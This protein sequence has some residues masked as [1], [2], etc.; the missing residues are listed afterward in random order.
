MVSTSTKET[1][2]YSALSLL[3]LGCRCCGGNLIPPKNQQ[4]KEHWKKT[5]SMWKLN[6]TVLNNQQVKEEITRE[7]RKYL[8]ARTKTQHSKTYRMQ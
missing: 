1:G 3:R 2:Q 7:I 5:T 4:Q 6:N 8:E